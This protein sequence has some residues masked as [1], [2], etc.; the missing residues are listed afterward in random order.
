MTKLHRQI[1]SGAVN[2]PARIAVKLVKNIFKLNQEPRIFAEIKTAAH[3]KQAVAGQ[4]RKKRR[5]ICCAENAVL[6][7]RER[8]AGR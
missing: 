3:V 4:A 6:N 1:S 5:G 2:S 8:F 7:L